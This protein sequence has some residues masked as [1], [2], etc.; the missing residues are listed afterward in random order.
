MYLS[1]SVAS[2]NSVLLLKSLL[3]RVWILSTIS[4]HNI[5]LTKIAFLVLHNNQ[6]VKPNSRISSLQSRK[7]Q[8][9]QI[10]LLPHSYN[11][12]STKLM[13]QSALKILKHVHSWIL[14][15]A[16]LKCLHYSFRYQFHPRMEA[17]HIIE[18]L[19]SQIEICNYY[20]RPKLLQIISL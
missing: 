5:K 15:L 16:L 12:V 1:E 9:Y 17:S 2:I 6:Y 4:Y 11:I 8:N 14:S 19:F 7:N 10:K 3:S 18:L 13:S 20:S